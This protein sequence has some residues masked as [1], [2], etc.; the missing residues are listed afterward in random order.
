MDKVKFTRIEL[1]PVEFGRE[2]DFS[3][4]LLLFV[5]ES[6]F[7]QHYTELVFTCFLRVVLI[8]HIWMNISIEKL[9]VIFV[10][11]HESDALIGSF[12]AISKVIVSLN[13]IL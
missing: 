1:T 3:F 12:T 6:Q 13:D 11:E 7:S 4:D 10:S 8:L 5:S 9:F 2:F